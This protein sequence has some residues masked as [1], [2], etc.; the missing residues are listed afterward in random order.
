MGPSTSIRPTARHQR[1]SERK[2]R[3]STAPGRTFAVFEAAAAMLAASRRW[4]A[5]GLKV[6]LVPTMGALHAGHLSLI[7]AARTENDIVV[8]SIFV[9]PLQF[10]PAEDFARYPRDPAHDT[11][12][13]GGASVD[14]VYRP[15]VE[16]MYPPGSSTRVH[17]SGVA[18]PLEGAARPGHFEGVTTV[19][20]KLFTAVEPDR[21][22][23]GQ[24]DAQQAAVVKRMARDL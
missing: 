15:S 19:V 9:N 10:G 14:A 11:G 22:Y 8:V 24:K 12:L 16:V 20:S 18:D 6:G 13:L 1:P 5:Q 23:F 4:R 17:V 2:T 7:E 3:S 21:A